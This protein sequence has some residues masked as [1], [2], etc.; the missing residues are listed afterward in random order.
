[1]PE[2]IRVLHVDDQGDF[3][4]I[5][6][7]YLEREDDRL[8]VITETGAPAGLDRLAE[9]RID[10]IVSDYQMPG[11]DGLEF[12]DAVREDYPQLPFIL[13]TGKGSEEIASEAISAGVTDYLQKDTGTDQYA[14]LAN[15]VCNAAEK[16]DA[17]QAVHE[18]RR[19]FRELLR[20]S[21]DYIHIVD[22]DGVVEYIT[23]SVED[24]LG[25]EPVELIGSSAFDNVHPEDRPRV[26]EAFRDLAA[27]P[28]AEETIEMRV[29]HRDGSHRW[30]EVKARNLLDDPSIEGIVANVRDI[31]ERK[32]SRAAVDW[33]QTVIRN[34]NE[35]VYVI[36][37]DLDLQ[38]VNYRVESVPGL[39]E[40]DL[41][42]APLSRLAEVGLLGAGELSD[43]E[44]AVDTL[45]AGDAAEVSLELAPSFPE[46][47]EAVELRLHPIHSD[48][49]GEFVLGTTRDVTARKE[50][51]RRLSELHDTTRE[52]MGCD[53]REAVAE[54]AV[55]AVRDI[56]DMPVNSV[57]LFDEATGALEP[58]AATDDALAIVGDPPT[59]DSGES[60]AETVFHD[61]ESRLFDDVSNHPDVYDPDTDLR[62]E[63]I[64][65]LGE[66]GVLF[67][68]ATEVGAFDQSDASLARILAANVEEALARIDREEALLESEQRY[69]T[70][71]ENFPDGGVFL[72]DHD[73]RYTLAGG[74]GLSAIGLSTEQM[75]G[76]T[77]HDLFP[78]DFAE[79]TAEMY[80]AVLDG[81][82]VVYEQQYQDNHYRVRAVPVR[83]EDGEV[84]AG[85]A[86]SQNVTEH[87]KDRLKLQQRNERLSEFAS[88]VSHDLRNPLNVLSGALELAEETGDPEH[89][90]RSYRAVD[91]MDALVDDLLTLA[92]Q[93][94]SIDDFEPVDL[95]AAVRECW[96]TVE[97][98]DAT[99]DVR[100][101]RTV[102]ADAGRLRQL[103]DNLVSN[104]VE[105]GS[106]SSRPQA[107]DAV[108]H[109][110]TSP[111]SQAPDDAVADGSGSDLTIT[112]GS[113]DDPPGF[114]VADDGVG[115]PPDRT[116]EVFE[117]GVSTAEQGTGLG[118]A[119][120]REVANA[121][122]WDV[123]LRESEGGGTRFDITG[124][125]RP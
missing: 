34:M 81:R 71:V 14:V 89:F 58:A 31:T 5:A 50:H 99:L 49:R 125:D 18:T 80:R 26:R 2:S 33:H 35:G 60:I 110:S 63:M 22:A 1:M 51:E 106:A 8:D 112:V 122:G 76:R 36:D 120:V 85:M 19:R 108:E 30:V 104:A 25:Y 121:H 15:R 53:S 57:Y 20:N 94:Q 96:R 52:F 117:R 17:Q 93:G 66:Y 28:G 77:P 102:M 9:E 114:Y 78:E 40:A 68:A 105:H 47:T 27:D 23:P 46:E 86:V 72:F 24:L 55:E 118:L 42:G 79:E 83:N 124:V 73:L 91:R 7:T 97:T 21:A 74:A 56:L 59:Y 123:T 11:M 16:F 88:I 37:P 116:D 12:L 84:V 13:F 95:A 100:T 70:L 64:L 87:R 119:I 54:S 48:Q 92:R 4:E 10:C 6:A 90:E 45:L 111:R 44:T 3:A 32:A 67:V 41:T 61:G 43:I 29:R 39:D 62:S 65:P 113:L 109:G 82:E 98:G 75:E 69:E 103:L 115:I 107:D 101:D 38:F